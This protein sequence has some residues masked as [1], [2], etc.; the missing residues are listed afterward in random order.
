MTVGEYVNKIENFVSLWREEYI[1][2]SEFVECIKNLEKGEV[3]VV[4]DLEISAQVSE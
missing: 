3:V 4:E 1:T 2:D